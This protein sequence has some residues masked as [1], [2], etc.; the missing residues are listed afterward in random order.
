[1]KRRPSRSEAAVV[2]ATIAV[3]VFISCRETA[4][5]IVYP[6][7]R[8]TVSSWRAVSDLVRG[9]IDGAAAMRENRRLKSEKAALEFL[10]KESEEVERENIRLRKTLGM[11]DRIYR[12]WITAEVISRGGAASCAHDMIRIRRGSSDGVTVGSPV[13]AAAGLVGLVTEVSPHT[14]EVRLVTDRT[15]RVS[16]HLGKAR[17]PV[18]VAGNSG[19]LSV[20]SSAA[21]LG[22]IKPETVVDGEEAVTSGLGGIYPEGILIGTIDNGRLLP[23]VNAEDLEEVFIR[24][25]K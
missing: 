19:A 5:E 22:E 14:A 24:H 18:I 9:A 6:V 10:R 20:L 15:I 8:A 7:E 17:Y 16:A 4:M 2:L 25:A 11:S 21:P 13:A 23:A 1:M 3:I 12:G